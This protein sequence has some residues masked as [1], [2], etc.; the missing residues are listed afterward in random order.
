ERTGENHLRSPHVEEQTLEQSLVPHEHYDY[1]RVFNARY[2]NVV[3]YILI[4]M[5]TTE[6]TIEA[7]LIAPTSRGTKKDASGGVRTVIRKDGM[8]CRPTIDF[9]LVEE[10]ARAKACIKGAGE[11]L[12]SKPRLRARLRARG[13]LCK[14]LELLHEQEACGG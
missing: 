11:G 13:W 8:A 5:A 1:T 9:L 2:E 7:A 6:A 3:G 4:L 10:A 12:S 14:E